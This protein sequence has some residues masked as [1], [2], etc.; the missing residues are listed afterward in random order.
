[1]LGRNLIRKVGKMIYNVISTSGRN[2]QNNDMN[3]NTNSTT[4]NFTTYVSFGHVVRVLN[5]L[6]IS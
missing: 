3:I 4:L 5:E 2:P 1:M 6:K